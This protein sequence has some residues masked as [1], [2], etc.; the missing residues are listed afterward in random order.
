MLHAADAEDGERAE[1][2]CDCT[3]ENGVGFVDCA[4]GVAADFVV[5]SM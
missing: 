5:R 4:D 1:A 2:G 3:G